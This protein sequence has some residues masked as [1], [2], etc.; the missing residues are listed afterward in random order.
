M[1]ASLRRVRV[2]LTNRFSNLEICQEG[3][4]GEVNL[5][6]EEYEK[7]KRYCKFYA[8]AQEILTTA[9]KREFTRPV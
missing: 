1:T 3:G 7:V 8:V 4:L 6:S 2:R 5:T 9:Y